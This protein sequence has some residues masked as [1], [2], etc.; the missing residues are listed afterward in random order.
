MIVT[1]RQIIQFWEI[2]RGRDDVFGTYD[3]RSGRAWQVKQPV[4][5]K[6]IRDHLQGQRPLG[7]YLLDHTHTCSVVA[8]FDQDEPKPPLLFQ[9]LA[10]SWNLPVYIERSK[11]KGYHAWMFFHSIGVPAAKPRMILREILRRV[12]HPTTEIF[13]KQ[14]RLKRPGQYGNFINLPLFGLL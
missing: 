9:R 13:P 4:T 10:R 6:V 7:V 3:P 1:D 11:S 8:D 12:G 5:P 14:D 2:F